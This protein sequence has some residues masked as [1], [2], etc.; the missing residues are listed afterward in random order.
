MESKHDR[1]LNELQELKTTND[2]TDSSLKTTIQEL[3]DLK[4]RFQL[5]V[6]ENKIKDNELRKRA[7]HIMKLETKLETKSELLN[8]FKIQ[9]GT[10]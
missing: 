1:A 6:D 3:E 7:L 10:S 4:E 5:M 9:K 8:E 2:L